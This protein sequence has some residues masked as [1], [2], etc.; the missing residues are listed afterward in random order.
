MQ[1]SSA[2]SRTEPTDPD[3]TAGEHQERR[4]GSALPHDGRFGP[5][6]DVRFDRSRLPIAS[7][8]GRWNT[9]DRRGPAPIPRKGPQS[10]A[11]ARDPFPERATRAGPCRHDTVGRGPQS[12][13]VARPAARR[14]PPDEPDCPLHDRTVRVTRCGRICVGRCKINLGTV[15]AGQLVG[16]R[17]IDDQTC[18]SASQ[19]L[20]WDSLTGKTAA[21]NRRPA[22][23]PRRKCRPSLRYQLLPMSVGRTGDEWPAMRDG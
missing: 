3:G 2:I 14:S 11:R 13:H 8:R 18:R 20:T 5:R 1:R 9:T 10:A 23:S 6:S 22:H 19:T 21:S 17:Q 15:F 4:S 12:G 7:S 16:I